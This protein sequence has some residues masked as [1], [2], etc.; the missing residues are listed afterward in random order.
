VGQKAWAAFLDCDEFI[1]LRKHRNIRELLSDIVPAGGALSFNRIKFG[2]DQ[3]QHFENKPV[4]SRFTKRAAAPEIYVK[5]IA[6][7]PDVRRIEL[8]FV[9]LF[10]DRYGVDCHG[11]PVKAAVHFSPSEDIAAVNHYFTKSF[12]EFRAKRLRGH[13]HSAAAQDKYHSTYGEELIKDEFRRFNAEANAVED[14]R[15]WDW[16]RATNVGAS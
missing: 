2:S 16:Y 7:L 8:H 13:A 14:T 3:Q 9:R 4:L 12:D 15:A 10:Y 11:N 6:Y 1:V 5:T